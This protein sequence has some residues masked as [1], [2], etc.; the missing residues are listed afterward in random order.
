MFLPR[1]ARSPAP[2]RCFAGIVRCP[3]RKCR[4]LLSK[5]D[6]KCDKIVCNAPGSSEAVALFHCF[7]YFLQETSAFDA[8]NR[9]S[10]HN[11]A[12][13]G[14]RSAIQGAVRFVLHS[15]GIAF[16]WH[17]IA[18][19]PAPSAFL[20]HVTSAPICHATCCRN[21]DHRQQRPRPQVPPLSQVVTLGFAIATKLCI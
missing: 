6:D 7:D 2:R 9:S 16:H 20:C 21:T 15:T 5:G 19:L 14:V 11:V 10:M 13:C 8:P 4:Q 17:S 3:M 12:V 1:S 18:L